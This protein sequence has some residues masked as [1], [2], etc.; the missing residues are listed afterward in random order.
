M[1]EMSKLS[2]KNK[3]RDILLLCLLSVVL[4]SV[5]FLVPGCGALIL[6][7]FVPLLEAER[8]ASERGVRRFWPWHYGTFVLWNAATTFWV[9]NAT[10]GGGVFAVLANALQMSLIFG[11]FRW[12]KKHLGGILPYLLLALLWMA[13]ERYY[14]TIAQISWPW[15]V[16]GNAFSRTLPL[17]QWYEYTGTLGGSLWAWAVN[18]SVFGIAAIITRKNWKRLRIN[19]KAFYISGLAALIILPV[20]VSLCIWFSYR[21]TDDP[22]DV[23]IAQPNIDPYNKFRAM[24]QDT[25]NAIL[26]DLFEKALAKC[27]SA[28]PVLLLAPETFTGD[29]VLD[30]LPESRT[31]RRLTSFLGDHPGAG[32]IFGAAARSYIFSP[33]RPSPTARYYGDSLWSESYNVAIMTD[34]NGR[35]EVFCKSKLVVGVEMM[36]YP[37]VF[38]PLDEL[39]GGVMGRDIGQDEISLLTFLRKGKEPVRTGCAICYESIYGE[40][41]TGYVRKGAE[42]LTVITNDSWWGDT[43]GYRQHLSYSSLRAIETRRDIARCAN[44]GISAIIDQKGRILSKTP[45]WE[46][47]TLEGKVNLNGKETFFVRN[48]DIAGRLSVFAGLLLLLWAMVAAIT[49]KKG[50]A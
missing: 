24:T 1:Q 29:I 14:L 7:A 2:N 13:W 17:A 6:V 5:P 43:P 27:D 47:C 36:P 20:A 23:V 38:R 8:I 32:L 9:C 31:F 22:V 46:P 40:Y 37:K 15:L 21:E 16:L 44:T 28:A 48:G 12:S 3:N 33:S 50:Q 49:K 42:L 39:L 11:I 30:H 26:Q 35:E 41:C 10:I 45:W 34:G 19:P 18:L 25:Q 4:L